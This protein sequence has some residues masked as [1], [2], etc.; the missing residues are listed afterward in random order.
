MLNALAFLRS[1]LPW[2][3]IGVPVAILAVN[4]GQARER[5]VHAQRIA[6][7]I[8]LGL[9]LGVALN[10]AGIWGSHSLGFAIGPLWGMALATIHTRES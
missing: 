6:I 9:L 8:S 4:L 5:E 7:G 1:A 10:G 2:V 3:L